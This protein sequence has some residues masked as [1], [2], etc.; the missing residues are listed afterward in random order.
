[1]HSECQD[2]VQSYVSPTT[3]PGCSFS[4]NKDKASSLEASP[5]IAIIITEKMVYSILVNG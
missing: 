5:Q 1:V 2:S 4:T 3:L